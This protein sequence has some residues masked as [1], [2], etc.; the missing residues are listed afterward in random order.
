MPKIKEVAIRYTSDPE[1]F[2][3]LKISEQIYSQEPENFHHVSN[4]ANKIKSQ[5]GPTLYTVYQTLLNHRNYQ[6]NICFISKPKLALECGVSLPT[7]KKTLNEL[8]ELGFLIW[9]TGY[10]GTCN[11]Y[12]F[13]KERWFPTWNDDWFQKKACGKVNITQSDG[14]KTREQKIIEEQRIEIQQLKS[15]LN[16]LTL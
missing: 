7:L 2:A 8:R 3:F 10:K 14:R 6:T 11:N 12:Y 15:A 4:Q 13:P 1:A 9:N 5:H 16:G